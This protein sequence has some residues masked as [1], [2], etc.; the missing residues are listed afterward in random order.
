MVF[1]G[2][3]NAW[4]ELWGSVKSNHRGLAVIDSMATLEL[5]VADTRTQPT[6]AN[7]GKSSTV[8]LTFVNPRLIRDRLDWKVSDRYAGSDHFAILYH[9]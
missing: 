4:A 5:E 8:D 7:G 6:H 2:D 9:L 3:F 1:A